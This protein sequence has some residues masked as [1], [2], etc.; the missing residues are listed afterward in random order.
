MMHIWNQVTIKTSIPQTKCSYLSHCPRV[1]TLP[2]SDCGTCTWSFVLSSSPSLPWSEKWFGDAVQSTIR[3][4]VP[5]VAYRLWLLKR[6]FLV[7]CQRA[8]IHVVVSLSSGVQ[9]WMK[10][11]WGHV[12]LLVSFSALTL[13]GWWWASRWQKFQVPLVIEGFRPEQIEEENQGKLAKWKWP[14]K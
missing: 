13:F 12:L 2:T 3:L 8:S 10:K 7:L 5:Y 4:I 11:R 6:H 9:W 1:L 14:A